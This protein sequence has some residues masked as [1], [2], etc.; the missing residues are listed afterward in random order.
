MKALWMG[1]EPDALALGAD[2]ALDAGQGQRGGSSTWRA[3]ARRSAR[4]EVGRCG[5][6]GDQVVK[7]FNAVGAVGARAARRHARG[8]RSP[9][10]VAARAR[11]LRPP[12]RAGSPPADARA[13]GH[14]AGE[15]VRSGRP[16]R[17]AGRCRP[18]RAAGSSA[19]RRFEQAACVVQAVPAPLARRPRRRPRAEAMAEAGPSG[20]V[21][22]HEQVALDQALAGLLK[23]RA[24]DAVGERV[25]LAHGANAS[26]TTEAQG[27]RGRA[28]RSASSRSSR[29]ASSACSAGGSGLRRC[30]ALAEPGDELLEEERVAAGRRGDPLALGQGQAPTSSTSR[31]SATAARERASATGVAPGEEGLPAAMALVEPSRRA[32]T[33]TSTGAPRTRSAMSARAHEFGLGQVGVV[34]HEHERRRRASPSITRRKAHAVSSPD[35][36]RATRARPPPGA[37]RGG[38]PSHAATS[39]IGGRP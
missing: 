30:A 2:S 24:R 38:T 16:P 26:P 25:H 9:G 17:G 18:G 15:R 13:L 12:L 10:Q 37:R 28:A 19:P 14:G 23:H 7:S 6:R 20:P 35:R 32:A 34:E 5:R 27:E 8:S 36:P 33:T 31:A 1:V 11:R 29:E 4:V 3:C 39:S 21:A 22:A